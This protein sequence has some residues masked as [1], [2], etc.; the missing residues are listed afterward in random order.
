MQKA[1]TN[2]LLE[3]HCLYEKKFNYKSEDF[4]KCLSDKKMWLLFYPVPYRASLRS[5]TYQN[6]AVAI[7]H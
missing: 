3:A 6:C 7:K 2:A 5:Y 4:Q 1:G